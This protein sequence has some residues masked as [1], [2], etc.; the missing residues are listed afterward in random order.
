MERTTIQKAHVRSS[1]FYWKVSVLNSGSWFLTFSTPAPHH[2]VYFLEYADPLDNAQ[3]FSGKQVTFVL[4]WVIKVLVHPPPHPLLNPARWVPVA[5][6]FTDPEACAWNAWHP[7][8]AQS[9]PKTWAA[10]LQE[11]GRAAGAKEP[12]HSLFAEN[13]LPHWRNQIA[14]LSLLRRKTEPA[15]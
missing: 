4:S 7:A 2:L 14:V 1:L 15:G 13:K 10:A 11:A 8:L 3:S 12:I 9:A 6:L 5:P